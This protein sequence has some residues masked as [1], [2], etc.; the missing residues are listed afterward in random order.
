MWKLFGDN[1]PSP[2]S[3]H[4]HLW[5]Q[6]TKSES[7][8]LVFVF[9][10][11]GLSKAEAGGGSGGGADESSDDADDLPESPVDP[12]LSPKAIPLYRLAFRRPG[13]PSMNSEESVTTCFESSVAGVWSGGGDQYSAHGGGAAGRSGGCGEKKLLNLFI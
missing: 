4:A 3:M 11:Q 1:E 10:I 9:Q 13:T 6:R 7:S 5:R 12:T 2:M 8:L